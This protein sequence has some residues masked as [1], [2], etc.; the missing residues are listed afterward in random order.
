M[1]WKGRDAMCLVGLFV[2][3]G[4]VN[5]AQG[6]ADLADRVSVAMPTVRDAYEQ[7]H[8][9]PE[10]GLQ[11]ER[12]AAHLRAEL[13]RMGF[14]EFATVE[15]LP[16][17]VIAIWDTGK[18]GPTIAL[19]A[20]LDARPTQ[21]S[22][23]NEPRSAIDGVMHNCGHDAH[24]AML[25]GAAEIVATDPDAFSGRIVFLFQ[26]AEEVKGGADDI[27]AHGVLQRL[28]VEAIFAQHVFSGLPVGEFRLTSGPAMAGSNYFTIELSGQGSH[29]AAPEDGDDLPLVAARL[30]EALTTLPAR[31]L[32]LA[33]RPAVLSV[34]H[35]Q[36]GDPRAL[37]VLPATAT[38]A[39]TIRAFEDLDEAP[40]GGGRSIRE[41]VTE[42]AEQLAAAHG[43][44]AEVSI[45]KGS[46]PT[47]NNRPLEA[48]MVPALRDI[49]PGKLEINQERGMFSEDFSYY[50]ASI[51]SL[52]FGLGIAKDSLGY[53]GVHS[54]EFNLHP[55]AL[56]HGVTLLVAL[57]QT[58][59][60][61][62]LST[63]DQSDD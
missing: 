11:E 41:L 45:R 8:T 57:A 17:A 25:L 63:L 4:W 2:L 54:S 19:R 33:N 31:R 12:T 61:V 26:P 32:P 48:L 40:E 38:I 15:S 23:D 6:A 62:D 30:T 37:N 21:E 50:T 49:L 43:V 39:G 20:E 16:T 34:T 27:V 13:E 56:E 5:G 44:S 53:A 3:A 55:E 10:L 47:V 24:A 46:P 35:V 14:R 42:T 29:A 28:G 36:T 60:Q 9:Y 18:A 59:G 58:A 7:F 1:N 52:Y 51:P 22:A